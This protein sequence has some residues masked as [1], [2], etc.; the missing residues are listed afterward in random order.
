MG[1]YFSVQNCWQLSAVTKHNRA[2]CPPRSPLLHI[3][4]ITPVF[5]SVHLFKPSSYTY[6]LLP[7]KIKRCSYGSCICLFSPPPGYMPSFSANST[8]ASAAALK[9][10]SVW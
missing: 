5:I 9:L 6:T 2:P 4:Q 7:T 8:R 10:G 1:I 3:M